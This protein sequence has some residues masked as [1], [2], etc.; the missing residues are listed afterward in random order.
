MR[1]SLIH[2]RDLPGTI[3]QAFRAV[4]AMASDRIVM[5]MKEGGS[6]RRYTYR[7]I[8]AQIRGLSA[9]LSE[10]GYGSGQRI[11]IVAEN[12]PE[13]AI[14]YLSIITVGATAVPLDI[15]MP[16]DLLL[17]SLTT[18]DSRMVFMSSQTWPLV[19]DLPSS[20]SLVNMDVA[21]ASGQLVFQD[22]VAQGLQ[23]SPVDLT[24]Q[25][26][27][28]ASLLYTSGTTKRPKG[29]LLTHRNF[30]T[31]AKALLGTGL[32]GPEDNFLAILP[33]HHAY[34]FMTAF[35]VPLMMGARITFLQSLKGP[36][37]L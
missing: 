22:L 14:A 1:N 3:P 32:A 28:V 16:R 6:Y 30:M 24:V 27:D 7:D 36:D 10:L 20:V 21:E 23:K 19:K 34:P 4:A 12:R 29:V 5:Q 18:S 9:G 33:L 37:L 2:P 25:P 35:L 15:Q 8:E 26:D 11:A 31:N 17:S 13:W